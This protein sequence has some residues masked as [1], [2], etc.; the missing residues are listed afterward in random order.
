[1]VIDKYPDG[2]KVPDSML[3]IG[4]SYAREGNLDKAKE[5]LQMVI[6]N[7]PWSNPAKIAKEKLKEINGG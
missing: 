2:N 3:K 4:L 1:M 6:N 7:Y 5:Y